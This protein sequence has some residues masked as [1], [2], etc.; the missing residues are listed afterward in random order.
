MTNG[1]MCPN[2]FDN[3]LS[4]LFKQTYFSISVPLMSQSM[5]SQSTT[6]LPSPMVGL[7][8]E[9]S[10]F[11]LLAYLIFSF[12]RYTWVQHRNMHVFRLIRPWIL[13]TN[14]TDFWV[15]NIHH[16]VKDDLSWTAWKLNI[17]VVLLNYQSK[18][19]KPCYIFETIMPI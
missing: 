6:K 16:M 11:Y 12:Y 1:L 4:V 17:Q 15:Y 14:N 18:C 8:K 19:Q 3:Y 7:E 13:T 9:K 5:K 2:Y 10:E